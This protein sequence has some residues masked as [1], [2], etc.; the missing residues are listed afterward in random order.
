MNIPAVMPTYGRADLE[1]E[2]GDGA[3]LTT[4]DGRRFL[5]FGSGIAVTALG[6]S[7]PH[8]VAALKDQAEKA[9]AYLK[10]LPHCGPGKTGRAASGELFC[11]HDVFLQFG[12]GSNGMCAEGSAPLP[13][14]PGR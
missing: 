13:S 6:H 1:F 14:S 7:H 9:V 10:S 4:T 12:C 2:R 5:D 11:R 8:L 3:W